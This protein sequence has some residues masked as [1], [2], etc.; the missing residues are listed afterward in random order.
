MIKPGFLDSG[1]GAKKKKSNDS[2]SSDKVNNVTDVS[3]PAVM[4]LLKQAVEFPSLDTL[5]GKLVDG[6]TL[7]SHK[8]G[9]NSPCVSNLYANVI[10]KPGRKS[11]NFHTL[12]T[13][14]GNGVDVVVP[15]ESIRAISERFANTTYG[16][17]LGKR[18]AYPVVANYVRNNLEFIKDGLSAIATK[19]GDVEL[20]DNIVMAMPKLNGEGLYTCNIHVDYVWKPPRYAC[21][22]VF[23]HFQEKCLKNIGACETKNLKK[24]SQTPRGVSVGQKVGFK[25]AKQVYQPV[26]KKPTTNTSGPKKKNMEPTKEIIDG[27]VTLVDDEGKPL[28]K[29]ESSGD[30]N[31]EDEVA[32]VDNEMA[33]FLARKDGYGTN[34]PLE[35]WK[36]Y[37]ENDDY[38]YDPY[39]DDMYKGQEFPD[40]IKSICDNLD[41]K[42]RSLIM[43][44][45]V[46]I[47]KKERILELKRRH[48]K[49]IVLT[50][51]TPYQGRYD[52]LVLKDFKMILRVTTAQVVYGDDVDGRCGV[53]VGD[54]PETAGG[55]EETDLSGGE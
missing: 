17:F 25:P 11:M 22:K 50:S 49:I 55:E 8:P 6:P 30:Y 54:G 37:Y 31:S 14:G 29:V 7:D 12:F 38:D 52:V 26:S 27:K 24:L 43:E 35:K 20:K 19:L 15:M 45:L 39:D 3:T 47:S 21:C 36:E 4:D 32:S 33:S 16:F 41:I 53:V 1:G 5:N 9:N 42:V 51:Y 13:P 28:E 46:K 10:G 40:K 48:L 23:G 34:S 18:V 44:Y 2:D